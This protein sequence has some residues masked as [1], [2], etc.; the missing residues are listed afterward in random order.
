VEQNPQATLLAGATDIGLWVTKQFKALPALIDL[1]AVAELK[2]IEARDDGTLAIGAGASLE[3]AW[4]ALVARH[5]PLREMQLRFASPAI[6]HAGTMGGNVANGSPIGDGP[7][8]L[9]AL[10]AD[11]VLR[12][13]AQQRRLPLEAFYL[14]YMENALQPGEFVEAL[15]LPLPEAGTQIRGYKIAKRYDSDISAVCA[16]LSLTLDGE[17]VREARLAFGGMAATVRRAAAAEAALRGRRWDEA[18]VA[19]AAAALASDFQPLSDMRASAGYRLRVAQAL[20]RRLW[21]ETRPEAS[22]APGQTSV[23]QA[24]K[25]E[26]SPA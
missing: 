22:L 4:D 8:A 15:H 24:V 25:F 5:P 1:G 21:L 2:R 10:G 16:G 20:L 9:I 7:P 12:R 17:T 14:G 19:A 18:A 6:R 26:G 11:I 3:A 13:G 23:W